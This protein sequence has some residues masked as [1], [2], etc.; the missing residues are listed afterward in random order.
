MTMDHIGIEEVES[1]IAHF[2]RKQEAEEELECC[3]VNREGSYYLLK[4]HSVVVGYSLAD[5][6]CC[7]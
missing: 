7:C 2:E 6:C 5:Y 3:S 1:D 4:L